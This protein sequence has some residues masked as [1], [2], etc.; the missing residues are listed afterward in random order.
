MWEMSYFA[1]ERHWN[2]RT[3]FENLIEKDKINASGGI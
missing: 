1:N 3:N 2:A